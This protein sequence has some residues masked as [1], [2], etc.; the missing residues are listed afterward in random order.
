[1]KKNIN[2][3]PPYGILKNGNKPTYSQY[4]KTLKN[5]NNNFDLFKMMKEKM[6][7]SMI[8]LY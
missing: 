1:M 3:D 4:K 6:I 2:D 7:K 5:N 8:I